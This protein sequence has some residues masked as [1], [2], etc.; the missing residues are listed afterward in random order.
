[1]AGRPK[2]RR[3]LLKVSGEVFG[4]I[5]QSINLDM[6][7]EFASELKD[8]RATGAELA[9][10]AGGGNI[11]RGSML[12]GKTVSRVSADYMGM[13]GTVIN[14]LALQGALEKMGIEARVMTPF[15][16]GQVSENFVRR[17][18]LYHLSEGR[19]LVLAGGTGNPYFTTDTAAALRAAEIG[20]DVLVKGT[21]VKGIYDR[22]PVKNQDATMIEELSYSEVLRD[23][24]RVMDGT[25]VALCRDN[26]IPIIVFNIREKGNL[27]KVLEG[28]KIG[29]IVK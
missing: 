23:D 8:A 28:E 29:T 2:V 3:L 9:V 4:G 10:V 15:A 1:M 27:N 7:E 11:L 5:E 17:T 12:S 16:I 19:I 24:L 26:E 22:D 18:A 25:A 13:L 20:A 14:A 6:V 21:K